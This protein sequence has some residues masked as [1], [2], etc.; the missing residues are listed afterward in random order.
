[1]CGD[2]LPEMTGE[3]GR[4]EGECEWR[5]VEVRERESER[6]GSKRRRMGSKEKKE[7]VLFSRA[8]DALALCFTEVLH[9]VEVLQDLRKVGVDLQRV[10]LR[11]VLQK[12]PILF[13][14][15]HMTLGVCEIEDRRGRGVRTCE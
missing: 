9:A 5:H 3:L 10:C 12:R 8:A 4:G 1:M 2:G 15:V 6:K 7:R 13:Q 14:S 11:T